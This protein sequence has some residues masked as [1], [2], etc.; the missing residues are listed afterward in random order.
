MPAKI[1][2][3]DDEP[4]MVRVAEF[5][6]AKGG[7]ELLVGRNGRQA[8]DIAQRLAPS[9]IIMDVLMPEMDGL[10]ALRHL[11]QDPRTAA[12]PVI[13]ITARGHV[14]TRQ[15][16]EESGAAVFLTKPF[17]PTILLQEARRLIGPHPPPEA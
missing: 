16:A 6:L 14:L 5:S 13:M 10:T 11:K 9:L 8:I 1:L 17:S 3:V 7:F 4:H 15:E 12:I 2:I